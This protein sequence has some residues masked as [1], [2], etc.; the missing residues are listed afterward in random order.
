ME[1]ITDKLDV[2]NLCSVKDNAKRTK[3]HVT[4]WEK[5]FAKDAA[6]KELLI[7]KIQRTLKTQH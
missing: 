2:K 6:D 7:Q 1:E 4:V 5:T 3:R